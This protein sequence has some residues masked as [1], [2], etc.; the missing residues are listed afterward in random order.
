MAAA[1]GMVVTFTIAPVIVAAAPG[2]V[3]R[4]EAIPEPSP[5]YTNV[6]D[7]IGSERM[8][9]EAYAA[10]EGLP[11]GEVVKR[12]SATG[13]I[14]C[15]KDRND[16]D[17]SAVLVGEDR[18]AL[19]G[20]ALFFT[21]EDIRREEGLGKV[22]HE[23]CKP[24]F[25]IKS[26]NFTVRIEGKE[27]RFALDRIVASGFDCPT[28]SPHGPNDWAI[29][30]LVKAVPE[31]VRPYGIG[32]ASKLKV[33]DPVLGVNGFSGDMDG[34]WRK[35]AFLL[36]FS[37]CQWGTRVNRLN[38]N[39]CSGS[40][41]SSGSALLDRDDELVGLHVNGTDDVKVLLENRKADGSF[42]I[43]TCKYDALTCASRHIPVDGEFRKALLAASTA[44]H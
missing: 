35:G 32:D 44:S 6:L 36:T 31:T 10:A 13:V 26:C 23:V 40:Y 28:R 34:P 11:L 41:G 15:S 21:D 37:K 3:S 14:G 30:K 18:I 22:T 17:S 7:I 33:G 20:H 24:R 29:V 38:S 4:G 25:P 16:T 39:N 8:S 19:N 5:P 1:L 42:V 9:S 12:F 27:T 2:A 43:Q